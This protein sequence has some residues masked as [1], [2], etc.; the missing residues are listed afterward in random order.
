[1]SEF[2]PLS[3]PFSRAFEPDKNG[4]DCSEVSKPETHSS[5]DLAEARRQG[6]QEGYQQAR[7]EAAEDVERAVAMALQQIADAAGS[8]QEGFEQSVDLHRQHALQAALVIA[9]K[10]AGELISRE[11]LAEVEGAVRECLQHLSSE[12]HVVVRTAEPLVDP[13]REKLDELSLRSGFRGK[14]VLLGEPDIAAGDCR[15]EWADGGAERRLDALNESLDA[16][17]QRYCQN[18]VRHPSGGAAEE[19]QHGQ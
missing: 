1:M 13:L 5:E 6:H 12:P 11:P 2:T 4:R 14:I 7:A 17:I 18:P 10:L 8:L 9:R 3:S 19:R 16:I 15:I